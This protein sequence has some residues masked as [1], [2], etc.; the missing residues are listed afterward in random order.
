MNA[1]VFIR[2]IILVSF[3]ASLQAD[4]QMWRFNWSGTDYVNTGSGYSAGSGKFRRIITDI[5]VPGSVGLQPLELNR[6]LTHD[7]SYDENTNT[8]YYWSQWSFDCD[9]HLLHIQGPQPPRVVV[10]YPY[11]TRSYFVRDADGVYRTR[12]DGDRVII[13]G[14]GAY[15]LQRT[16]GTKVVFNYYGVVGGGIYWTANSITDPNGL[17]KSVQYRP[18]AQ[19]QRPFIPTQV[20]DSSGRWI[21]FDTDGLLVYRTYSSDGQSVSYTWTGLGTPYGPRM[22][23]ADYCAT[24]LITGVD[25]R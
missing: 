24:K 21:K 5:K 14:S 7:S 23:A 1:R 6:S 9:Y 4:E 10:Y 13:N 17:A 8:F 16:D 2:I 15:E 25:E 20:T 3:A 22:L 11:G 18:Y 12:P 19:G